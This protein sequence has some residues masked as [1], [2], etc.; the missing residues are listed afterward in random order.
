MPAIYDYSHTVADSEIDEIGVAGN[1]TYIR[2]MMFAATAHSGEQGLP[3]EEYL[4]RGHGWVVRSHRI[5]Y[6]R[7]ALPGDRI[8]VRTWVATLNAATSLRRYRILRADT[9]ELLATAETLWAFIDF[10]TRRPLRVPPDIAGAFEVV[11]D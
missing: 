5:E 3:T 2:W 4:R 7:P 1:V 10:D 6:R 8:V 11:A 9:D